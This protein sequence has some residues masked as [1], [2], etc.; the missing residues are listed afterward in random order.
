MELDIDLPIR[1][2]LEYKG[3]EPTSLEILD[4]LY[5][6]LLE[7]LEEERKLKFDA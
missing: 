2:Q 4:A 3:D 5:T 1:L 6:A 7:Q